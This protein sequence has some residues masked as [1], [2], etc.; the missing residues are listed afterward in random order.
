LELTTRSADSSLTKQG[1]K[2]KI[3]FFEKKG[4]LIRTQI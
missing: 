4:I 3:S 2:R 1:I